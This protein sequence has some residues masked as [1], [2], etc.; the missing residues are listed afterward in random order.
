[1]T[2]IES[3]ST[4]DSGFDLVLGNSGLRVVRRLEEEKSSCIVLVRGAPGTGKT[5]MAIHLAL[6]A[7]RAR[8]VA[9]GYACV[10]ILPGEIEAQCEALW[11]KRNIA[12]GLSK[13]P[14][15][16]EQ[17]VLVARLIDVQET[18]V[19]LDKQL[20]ELAEKT[21][22]GAAP[23]LVIDSLLRGSALGSQAEREVIDSLCKYAVDVGAV[24]FLVEEAVD[25][26]SPWAWSVD[27]VIDLHRASPEERTTE[28][29]MSIAKHRFAPC[30]PG[31]HRW[32]IVDQ[33]VSVYPRPATYVQNWVVPKFR[34]S[35]PSAKWVLQVRGEPKHL[36]EEAFGDDSC[37][38]VMSTSPGYTRSAALALEKLP[39][40]TTSLL[41]ELR[42]SNGS[43]RDEIQHTSAKQANRFSLI[44]DSQFRA[45]EYDLSKIWRTLEQ[46][47]SIQQVVIGDLVHWRSEDVSQDTLAAWSSL[48]VAL[49]RT[50]ISVV[51]YQTIPQQLYWDQIIRGA[52]AVANVVLDVQSAS[53]S[54]GPSGLRLSAIQAIIQ[55][56]PPFSGVAVA[57]DR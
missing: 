13:V 23:V 33:G 12:F 3:I 7:A 54:S 25:E 9:V 57:F 48:M 47:E 16:A 51:M 44:V 39:E 6:V 15:A 40:H 45:I 41:I 28:R 52:S 2:R 37:C 17:E 24:L 11:P 27:T 14:L 1:M 53:V 34:R 19:P 31:P 38:L 4:G 22:L 8:K 10:E 46:H 20:D 55:R 29:S 26:I 50:G 35:G 18:K 21:A 42:G 56:R 43:F 49:M 36:P 30:D 5:A 32:A